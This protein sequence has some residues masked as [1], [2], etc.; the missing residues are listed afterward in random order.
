[1]ARFATEQTVTINTAA[2]GG[3]AELLMGMD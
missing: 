3:N 2:S 1:L